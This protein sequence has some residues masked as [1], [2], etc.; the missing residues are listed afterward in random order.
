MRTRVKICGFTRKADALCAAMLGVDALGLV[1]YPP[2]P[3]AVSIDQA[4]EIVLDLPPFVSI[5]ALFVDERPDRVEEVI[6]NVGVDLLQFHGDESPEFCNSFSVPYIKAVRMDGRVEI[7]EVAKRYSSAR[8]LLL[9]AWH[10]DRKGGTG[11][12]FDWQRFPDRCS[13]PIILAG[14]LNAEN[15]GTALT[16]T[17]PFAVDVSS[18]VEIGKGLK[19]RDK[20][21]AFVKEVQRFDR[22]ENEYGQESI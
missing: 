19:D 18:G 12:Q 4:R 21:I 5:V 9:D 17:R 10:P 22:N 8:G 20:M 7:G 2:S 1:F 11:L 14:G 16:S 13:L 15:V 6:E 3:R